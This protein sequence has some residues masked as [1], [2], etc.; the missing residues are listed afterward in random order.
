MI[1]GS[2]EPFCHQEARF[3]SQAPRRASCA[4]QARGSQPVRRPYTLVQRHI[5]IHVARPAVDAAGQVLEAAEAEAAQLLHGAGAARADLPLQL[6]HDLAGR[7]QLAGAGLHLPH[8]NEL[9][10]ESIH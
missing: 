1:V 3:G 6:D 5:R 8:G 10:V 7:A 4:R 9:S 2:F